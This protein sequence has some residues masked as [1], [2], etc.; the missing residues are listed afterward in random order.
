MDHDEINY[1]PRKRFF[2]AQILAHI[3]TPEYVS[4]FDR[5]DLTALCCSSFIGQVCESSVDMGMKVSY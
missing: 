3:D 5:V 1:Y 4:I 2:P